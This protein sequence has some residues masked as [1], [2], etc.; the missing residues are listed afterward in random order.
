MMNIAPSSPTGFGR[1]AYV[2]MYPESAS[3]PTFFRPARSASSDPP[4]ATK[5]RSIIR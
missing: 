3:E 5:S 1:S 4:T 2:N